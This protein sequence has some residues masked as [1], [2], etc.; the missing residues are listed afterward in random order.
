MHLFSL[1]YP[2]YY[3]FN[4][5]I[6]TGVI[7]TTSVNGKISENKK[8]QLKDGFTA[9]MATELQGLW[10]GDEKYYD[11]DRI[12]PYC[13]QVIFEP[14]KNFVTWQSS[15]A[16]CTVR[17]VVSR[18]TFFSLFLCCRSLFHAV[19]A[20]PHF[21]FW[22]SAIIKQLTVP[23]ICLFFVIFHINYGIKISRTAHSSSSGHRRTPKERKSKR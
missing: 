17:I 20:S 8:W 3:I 7:I 10:I 18:Y 12:H 6:V 13:S 4:V 21:T 23:A 11:G 1:L 22:R 19:F 16:N 9:G 15:P 2:A 5:V 14:T